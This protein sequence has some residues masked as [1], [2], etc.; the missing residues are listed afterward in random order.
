MSGAFSI[1]T[2]ETSGQPSTSFLVLP[3]ELRLQVYGHLVK[4][5]LATGELQGV[6]GL[7]FSYRE[8]Y[9]EPSVSCL[10]KVRSLIDIM[11]NW[12]IAHPDHAPLLTQL[13]D[14]YEFAAP[15]SEITVDIPS[16]KV[17]MPNDSDGP[18]I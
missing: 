2:Q 11:K 12:K 1:R 8:I 15:P 13:A 7:L 17:W 3:P 16:S 18:C 9:D 6:R 4:S 10:T 14:Y 5:C